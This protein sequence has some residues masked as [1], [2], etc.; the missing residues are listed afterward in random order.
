MDDIDQ[1]YRDLGSKLKHTFM[2]YNAWLIC[3]DKEQ[4]FKI[5]LKPSVRYALNNGGLDCELLQFV[6]FDGT[7]DELR[8]RGEHIRNEGFRSSERSQGNYHARRVE[9]AANDRPR[10]RDDAPALR[11]DERQRRDKI[12]RDRRLMSQVDN[13]DKAGRYDDDFDQEFRHTSTFAKRIL[14]DRKPTLGA[15][16]EVPI[17]HGRRKSWKRRGLDEPTDQKPDGNND[18]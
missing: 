7:Y 16:M 11:D 14:R 1:F 13:G 9:G 17:V 18:E 5:G 10:R 15:D 12:A 3:S 4:S 2:G 8:G 6:I